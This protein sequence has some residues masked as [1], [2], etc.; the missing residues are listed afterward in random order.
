M[1]TIRVVSRKRFTQVDR[2]AVN[3]RL[4][5]FKARGILVWLLDKPDDWETTAERIE[6]Q[7]KEGREAIR[8]GLKELEERKYLQRRRWRDTNGQW[9]YEWL[10]TESP[11]V[12]ATYGFPSTGS[13]HPEPV[14]PNKTETNTDKRLDRN[15]KPRNQDPGCANCVNGW[16]MQDD[17]SVIECECR[18]DTTNVSAS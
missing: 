9:R 2:N 16:V 3:D 18:G 11:E 4:L 17:E 15:P 7:G 13:R 10:V 12:A 6:T 14:T 5:S 8:S 1:T